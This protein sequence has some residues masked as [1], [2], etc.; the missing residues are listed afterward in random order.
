MK[1]RIDHY[2]FDAS[3]GTITFEEPFDLAQFTLITNVSHDVDAE[4]IIYNFTDSNRGGTILGNVLTLI[5]TTTS[6]EDTDSLQIFIDVPDYDQ[7][8]LTELLTLGLTEIV[9]QLQSIRN[10]GG[11]ADSA[12]RVRVAI[13][14]GSVGIATNQ[15]IRN[16]T[17]TLSGITN[18]GG[19]QPTLATINLSNSGPQNLRN[20]IAVS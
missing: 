2:Q 4:R 13:E 16:I 15:D 19:I 5:A 10:D 14:S 7:T 20:K 11:M 8:A 9:R 17:G 1:K 3:S 6:M 18:I 12:G